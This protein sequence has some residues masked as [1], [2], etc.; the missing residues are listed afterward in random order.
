MPEGFRLHGA[1][2]SLRT[3]DE[4]VARLPHT[5]MPYVQQELVRRREEE[6][7]ALQLLAGFANF[8]VQI[9]EPSLLSAPPPLPTISYLPDIPSSPLLLKSAA[10]TSTP[11]S[12]ST[13]P[14]ASDNTPVRYTG[15]PLVR[16]P[17]SPS[18][19]PHAKS[20]PPSPKSPSLK[21]SSKDRENSP[22]LPSETSLPKSPVSIEP[23]LENTAEMDDIERELLGKTSMDE[24]T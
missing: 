10:S 8:G 15:V 5:Y 17:D 13:V 20:P 11:S 7:A 6:A 1:L 21:D 22:E 9:T 19:T 3:W 4:M 23:N 14:D 24:T 18:P 16:I 12:S 2:V